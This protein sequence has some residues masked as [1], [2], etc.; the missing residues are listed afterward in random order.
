M[1]AMGNLQTE[2]NAKHKDQMCQVLQF[3]KL[4]GVSSEEIYPMYI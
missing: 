2:F 3:S 4:S 1:T